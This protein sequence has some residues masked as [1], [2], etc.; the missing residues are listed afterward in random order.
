MIAVNSDVF[1][2]NLNIDNYADEAFKWAKLNISSVD[3]CYCP[4]LK[5]E[6]HV[7]NNNLRH[8]IYHKKYDKKAVFDHSIISTIKVLLELI[9]KAELRYTTDHKHGN[10]DVKSVKMLQSTVVVDGIKKKVELLIKEVYIGNRESVKFVFYNHVF[11][12]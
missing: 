8:T 6:V 3:G 4:C 9:D 12:N 7:S 2:V 5:A 10:E 11:I 1:G